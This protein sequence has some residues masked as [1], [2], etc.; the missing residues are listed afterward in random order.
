MCIRDRDN[1]IATDIIKNFE[2]ISPK[3]NYQ[4]VARLSDSYHRLYN[5]SEDDEAA[6][7]NF[8]EI[9]EYN[10]TSEIS[11]VFLTLIKME[12]D[13]EKGKEF[14]EKY[15]RYSLDKVNPVSYTHLDVY[16][17]QL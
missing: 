2:K 13:I 4:F 3:E 9:F 15:N 6:I 14:F 8:T 5:Q 7:K 17:R 12:E 10:P 16:K 11:F 1:S